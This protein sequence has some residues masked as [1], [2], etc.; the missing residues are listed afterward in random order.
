MRRRHGFSLVELLVVIAIIAILAALLL[1][2][3]QA[4]RE[5][6][7]RVACTN[8]MKQVALAILNYSSSTSPERL[9]ARDSTIQFKHREF[10]GAEP[11][12]N[13]GDH[14]A[15]ILPYL[16]QSSA[17][18]L[19]QQEDIHSL[20]TSAEMAELPP[21]EQPIIVSEYQ[22]PSTIGFPN[23][24]V[25]RLS[26]NGTLLTDGFGTTDTIRP[27][28]ISA[29]TRDEFAEFKSREVSGA[30]CMRKSAYVDDDGYSRTSFGVNPD[31]RIG[32]KLVWITD[33][34]SQT[35]LMV[36]RSM[37]TAVPEMILPKVPWIIAGPSSIRTKIIKRKP[38]EQRSDYVQ[39]FAAGSFH[40]GG[41]NVTFCD[42]HVK[43][44]DEGIEKQN[45]I[46]IVTRAGF[47][48]VDLS[49]LNE[50]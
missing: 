19:L 10:D 31:Y 46:A 34:L 49:Y 35:A 12:I 7:R 33:G 4:A 2:A 41:V 29:T 40:T 23:D 30:W 36:E 43:F 27:W 11:H 8:S 3:V 6:A 15:K 42:G 17:Y 22:C 25:L 37:P 32:A 39:L 48:E 14:F 16:E 38:V 28:N 5:Q 9:P 44:V 20:D 24:V 18:D 45:F 13:S 1:P 50:G 47:N 21:P 26:A